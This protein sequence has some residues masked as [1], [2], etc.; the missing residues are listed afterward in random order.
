[1]KIVVISPPS[2]TK[3]EP[4]TVTE[5]F[6]MGLMHFHLKKP[7]YEED[8]LIEYLD[9]IPS[10]YHPRIFLH[11]HYSL[12]TKYNVAGIHLNKKSKK[13]GWYQQL[14]LTYLRYRRNDL[15]VTAS[16]SKLAS[17]Y[18]DPPI[19]EYAFLSP[20]FES[21][22]EGKY[23]PAFK[24]R[25]LMEAL[26]RAQNPIIAYGGVEMDKIEKVIDLGFQGMALL[27]V[28]WNDTHPLLAFQEILDKV[29]VHQAKLAANGD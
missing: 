16:Y 5:M 13:P 10:E 22:S 8:K 2:R 29:K 17:L 21:L 20:I 12:I 27:G 11:N 28:V 26:Q 19:Y 15:K 9:R 1:V 25:G 23:H 3:G 4:E 14:R 24:E 6:K 7:G 18:F